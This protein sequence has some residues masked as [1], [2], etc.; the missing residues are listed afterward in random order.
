MRNRVAAARG[1]GWLSGDRMGVDRERPRPLSPPGCPT[2]RLL[3]APPSRFR[4]EPPT[5]KTLTPL[6]PSHRP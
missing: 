5:F 2:E 1:A 3:P 4:Q 6:R